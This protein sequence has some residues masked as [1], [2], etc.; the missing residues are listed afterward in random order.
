MF[1][2]CCKSNLSIQIPTYCTLLHYHYIT[3]L[4]YLNQV[5]L[6]RER[7]FNTSSDVC[8]MA[9]SRYCDVII[10]SSELHLKSSPSELSSHWLLTDLL[11]RNDNNEILCTQHKMHRKWKFHNC[12]WKVINTSQQP[13]SAVPVSTNLLLAAAGIFFLR[14]VGALDVVVVIVVVV[15][16]IVL[17][18]ETPW[19]RKD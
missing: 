4:Q 19:T 7:H 9:V 11:F 17:L 12:H 2:L 1:F 13:G 6:N 5:F 3:L 10:F 15:L 18:V 8:C 14:P 16:V